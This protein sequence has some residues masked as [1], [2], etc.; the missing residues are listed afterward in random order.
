L[1]DAR[2]DAVRSHGQVDSTTIV[3]IAGI[4]GTVIAASIGAILTPRAQ[5]RIKL[6][7]R[8]R[9][10]R[11]AVFGEALTAAQFTA[12]RLDRVTA[13]QQEHHSALP[14]EPDMVVISGR[15]ALFGTPTVDAAWTKYRFAER[16]VW[17]ALEFEHDPSFASEVG[18]PEFDEGF[19]PI[20]DARVAISHLVATCRSALDI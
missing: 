17:A 11:I 9:H 1:A 2:G 5:A 7:S 14:S 6:E 12:A 8:T 3:G 10:E 15:M 13:Y 19:E 4:I 16:A 18:E 20:K